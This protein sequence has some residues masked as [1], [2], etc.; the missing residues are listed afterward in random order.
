MEI[1]NRFKARLDSE[2]AHY[3]RLT[4]ELRSLERTNEELLEIID[5][6]QQL[7]EEIV[8]ELLEGEDDA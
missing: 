3:V 5:K 1:L 8:T 2:E 6:Q 7:I 4:E